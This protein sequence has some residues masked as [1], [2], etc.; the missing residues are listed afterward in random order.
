ME[1]RH[2]SPAI[3]QQILANL[4]Y[5]FDDLL[6]QSSSG[7]DDC[8]LDVHIYVDFAITYLSYLYD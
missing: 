3:L 1:D 2:G 8:T 5:A 4:L 6:E 7:L